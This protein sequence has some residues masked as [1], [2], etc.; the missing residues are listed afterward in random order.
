MAV[1]HPVYGGGSLKVASYITGCR[2]SFY[3]S[4][5]C[6]MVIFYYTEKTDTVREKSDEAAYKR[7]L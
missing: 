6:I 4:A 3:A 5:V 7:P 2:G 1:Q